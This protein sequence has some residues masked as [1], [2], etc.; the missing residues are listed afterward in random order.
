VVK[1]LDNTVKNIALY[2]SSHPSV[3]GVAK[4]MLDH[5]MGI[6]AQKEEVLMG[7]INGVLYVDEYLFYETTPYSDNVLGLMNLFEVDDI[8]FTGEVGE[9][10]IL[11]LAE[12]MRGKEQSREGF[13]G[14]LAERGITHIG[15]KSFRMGKGESGDLPTK[16]LESYKDAISTMHGLFGEI[17]T[18]KLPPLREAEHL[19]EG[20]IDRL[21]TNRTSLMLLSSLKGYDVYTYQHCVNVGI[22]ALLL[23]EAE[24][25]DDQAAKHAAL[26]GMMHDIGKVKVPP[27]ILNKA[28]SLTQREW[29]A[30][31]THPVHSAEVV[32]GMGGVE[33]IALAVEGHHMHHDGSGYPVTSGSGGPSDIARLV[34]VVDNY[35]AITTVRSYKRP[36]NPVE[37][38]A[39]L[40]KGRGHQFDP[41]H[42]DALVAMVGA[43]PPGVMVRLSSNE[44]GM[45]TD[46]GQKKGK[47][48]VKMILDSSNRPYDNQW[49]LDLSTSE[50]QGRVV[51]AVVDPAV[52][53]L[54]VP[55]TVS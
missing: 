34:S 6:L 44:I 28:G 43:Y 54:E 33:D 37:A 31:K 55:S 46:A 8:V 4:R 36:M 13:L 14:Q 18:G 47:P 3:R 32:R 49:D 12:I 53:N 51:A 24:G 50:A 26:A 16:G 29:E 42:V 20:F 11:A 23:A 5:L 30:I 19:V 48:V 45:V 15:L 22:L 38:L 10:D 25:L 27:D 7:V 40:E 41:H 2:P 39:F 9:E 35:D 21:K 52:H 1:F 17:R